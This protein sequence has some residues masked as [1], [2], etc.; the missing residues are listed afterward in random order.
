MV[1]MGIPTENLNSWRGAPDTRNNKARRHV[2]AASG[3]TPNPGFR[4]RTWLLQHLAP[5]VETGGADVV[6][7][8]RSPV[9]GSAAIPGTLSALSNGPLGRDFVLLDAMTEFPAQV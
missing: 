5:T 7:Q 9:V 6:T 2:S 8:V 1:I 4:L 3:F